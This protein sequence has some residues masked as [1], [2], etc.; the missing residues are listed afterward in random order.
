MHAPLRAATESPAAIPKVPRKT[1]GPAPELPR[2]V[3]VPTPPGTRSDYPDRMT[4]ASRPGSL[5]AIALVPALCRADDL[6]LGQPVALKFL[7]PGF[8]AKPERLQRFLDEVRT[9]R[10]VSHPNVCRIYDAG[11]TDGRMVFRL[12]LIWVRLPA[13]APRICT[14]PEESLGERIPVVQE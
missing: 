6:K 14:A 12:W 1:P 10:Q 8:D 9:A 7:P 11:E 5:L 3:W 13:P 2:R 4:A